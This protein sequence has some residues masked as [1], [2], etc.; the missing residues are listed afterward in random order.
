MHDM[1]SGVDSL[2]CNNSSSLPPTPTGSTPSRVMAIPSREAKEMASPSNHR[3]IFLNVGGM[4]CAAC[5]GTIERGLSSTDGV[6]YAKISLLTES[7]EVLFDPSVLKEEQVIEEIADLGFSA[8]MKTIATKGPVVL[9]TST[10]IDDPTALA[11]F[12]EEQAGV[13]AARVQPGKPG[14]HGETTQQEIHAEVDFTRS[15]TRTLVRLLQNSRGIT[16]LPLENADVIVRQR[17]ASKAKSDNDQMVLR[18]AFLTSLRWTLPVVFITMICPML[19]FLTWLDQGVFSFQLHNSFT[20]KQLL[21]WILV[22]PVQFGVGWR[23]YVAA[24]KSV[25]HGSASMDVLVVLGSTAAYMYSAISAIIC[26]G[27]VGYHGPVFFE[28]SAMLISIILLGRYVESVAKGRTGE[29][30]SALISLQ[31]SQ[32]TLVSL[33]EVTGTIQDRE[34][35][36]V[37]MVEVGD[38]LEVAKGSQAPVDGMVLKG[39]SKFDEALLTGESLPV[40]KKG[41]DHIIGATVNLEAPILMRATGV[42]SETT[43]SKIVALVNEAQSNKAP[44]QAF[45][46]AVARFFVPLV[47]MIALLTFLV[48]WTLLSAGVAPASYH[49]A[50][51][52]NFLFAFMFGVAVLV[53]SC[54]CSLGLATPTAVMVG[55]GVGARLGILFKGGEPLELCGQAKKVLFD[56]TGTL[57][58]GHPTVSPLDS[59]LYTKETGSTVTQLWGLLASAELQSE[60][61]LGKAVVEF[62]KQQSD[63]DL[64]EPTTFEAKSGEGVA[65]EVEGR[66]VLVGSERFLR[67]YEIQVWPHAT[68]RL[69]AIQEQG[70]IAICAAVDGAFAAVVSIADSLKPEAALVVRTLRQQGIEVCMVTGDSTSTA[71]AVGHRL[72]IPAHCIFSEVTPTGKADVVRTLQQGIRWIPGQAA[73]STQES[74]GKAASCLVMFVGDGVNDAPALAQANIG[75]ALGAGTDIAVETASVVLMRENLTD[76]LCAMDLSRVVLWRIHVNF[77]WALIYNVVA[78]PMAAGIF[79]PWTHTILSPAVAAAAMGLSSVSVVLSSLFIK[80]YRRPKYQSTVPPLTFISSSNPSHASSFGNFSSDVSSSPGRALAVLAMRAVSFRETLSGWTP[81]ASR[82]TQHS[83]EKEEHKRS[84]A[85]MQSSRTLRPWSMSG[86]KSEHSRHE[87]KMDLLQEDLRQERDILSSPDPT[88]LRDMY[89][90]EGDS[91]EENIDHNINIDLTEL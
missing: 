16:A 49:T 5:S 70:H 8:S 88:K 74:K 62:V 10:R 9:V 71:M 27:D 60:H 57:T 36:A 68:E 87:E 56:K 29:A 63:I 12:L 31:P 14:C 55:T 24:Y 89:S 20:V 21:I 11:A 91:D 65:A 37:S 13:L 73:V 18:A 34:Q 39:S 84:T 23:F 4:T 6:I 30:L 1:T 53:I 80:F 28:T 86:G 22:S 41:G 15:G 64:H 59:F 58:R 40:S 78:I 46:D 50:N 83:P 3:K 7:A 19:P 44:V 17:Q 45:A 67:S 33:D 77:V 79:Y 76:V 42:G 32:A 47:C 43:L 26:F 72:S 69:K 48:W 90:I 25:K 2:L 75:V 51:V 81:V 61:L 54:P 35:I 66:R 85:G 38:V 52:S 82:S